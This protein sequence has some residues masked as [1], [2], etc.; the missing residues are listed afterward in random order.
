MLP[1][2]DFHQPQIMQAE[3]AEMQPAESRNM[4]D[5]DPK[6]H[7]RSN[8]QEVEIELHKSMQATEPQQTAERILLHPPNKKVKS[9]AWEHFGYPKNDRGFVMED[10]FPVCRNCGRK[11]AAKG[12]NTSNMFAH[13]RE[14]HPSVSHSLQHSKD[15]AKK[16]EYSSTV[17]P[18][19]MQSFIKGT[20]LDPK[21]KQ[22]KDLNR[23]VAYFIAKDMMPLRLVEKPGFLHLMK[24]A[25]PLYKVPSRT[26]FSSNEIPRM[27]KEVRSSVEQQLKEAMWYAVTT[28]LWTSSSGGGEPFISFTVHYLSSDWKLICHCLETLFFPEDHTAEHISEMFDNILQDWNLPKESLCGITTDNAS[29]MIEF[30][31][32]WLTC[33]GL[34]LNLAI[35]KVLKMQRVESAVRACRHLVQAFSR[36]WKKK[37]DLK[38]KQSDLELPEHALIHDVVT[39]WGSTFEMI[40]RFL[41]QQQAVCAV[42]AIDRGTWHLMPK[43]SD[44]ATLENVNKI[45]QPLHELTDALASEKRVTL[46]SLTPILEHIGNEILKEQTEDSILTSQ[47]K[48]IMREDLLEGRYTESMQRVLHI[49]CLLDPRFK[50]SFCKN[51]DDTVEACIEEA[52]NLAPMSHSLEESTPVNEGAEGTE[53]RSTTS[54][55]S[56]TTTTKKEKG[57]SGLLQRIT[58]SRQN[59]ATLG[60]ENIH[61]KVLSE[62]SMYISLPTISSDADP[63]SWWKMHRQEM[64]R[65]A[66]VARK[67]LCIPATSV[68]SERFFSTSGHILSPQWS[69]MS[70]ET[71]NMLT[72]LHHNLA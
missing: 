39:R 10:G 23:A 61:E 27:Y 46:S 56:T 5:A 18:T 37:R 64:P 7:R 20:K 9:A 2:E 12:G 48:T 33:F 41:E 16:T 11:V 29:N 36:S 43:D 52:E 8:M 66:N 22:A 1:E 30:P 54:S 19:V 6:M 15:E 49:S 35:N 50:R 68:P 13:L 70:P 38:K 17:Q 71:L 57:L 40:S 26:Y 45:L 69:R 14:H 34:N 62:V 51:L 3:A 53:S 24:K 42:L 72:F 65:L 25:I 60:N 59:K 4:Q 47:M 44:I 58:S 55:T 21:S 31:C 32:F 63:L 28:D 67:Y